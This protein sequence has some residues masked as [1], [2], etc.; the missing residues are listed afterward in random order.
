MDEENEDRSPLLTIFL[1]LLVAAVVLAGWYFAPSTVPQPK[2]GVVRLDYEIFNETAYEITEQLRYARAH[3]DIQAV[4]LIINSPGGSAVY[5]EELY[6][7][8][9]N[10]R[11][12][13]PVVASIDLL[14]ASGAYYM[15]AAADEIYSKPTSYIGSVGVISVLPDSVFL[16]GELITTGPYKLF[17]GSPDSAVRQVELAKDSFLEAVRLGRGDRL[18]MSLEE[19]SNAEMYSGVQAERF[20]LI[21][22]LLSTDE[23][24]ARAAELAGFKQYEVVELYPLAFNVGGEGEEGNTAVYQPPLLDPA[25][26]W[27]PPDLTA[28]GLYFRY[29]PATMPSR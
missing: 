25:R 8:V 20:G 24:I 10:T 5:S 4:V 18:Q 9:L 14:A 22:G 29:V 28:P 26:L 16:E 1:L 21:D 11:R 15:A 2:I 13:M 7:D 17:G 23:V 6:L 27:Q 19:L 3:E 12:H